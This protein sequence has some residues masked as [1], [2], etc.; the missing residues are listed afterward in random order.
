METYNWCPAH[1]AWTQHDPN[2]NTPNGCRKAKEQKEAR[3]QNS[4]SGK[5]SFA[6]AMSAV[7]QDYED[8]MEAVD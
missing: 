5:T 7:I 4:S 8:E 6:R 3:K 1:Q 2:P